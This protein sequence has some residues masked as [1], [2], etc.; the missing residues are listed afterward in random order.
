MFF[1]NG[2]YTIES[3]KFL[4]IVESQEILLRRFLQNTMYFIEGPHFP[5]NQ[6]TGRKCVLTINHGLADRIGAEP[7]S[8]GFDTRQYFMAGR[9]AQP[10]PPWTPPDPPASSPPRPWRPT[11]STSETPGNQ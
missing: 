3:Y 2:E 9:N 7:R 6:K 8:L 5:P 1:K 11:R 10:V 4:S